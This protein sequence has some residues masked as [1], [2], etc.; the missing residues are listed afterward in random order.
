MSNINLIQLQYVLFFD[1]IENRPDKLINRIDDALDGLFDKMPTILP[2]ADDVPSDLPS[3][4]MQSSNGQFTC[5]ISRT[6]IDIIMNT[7]PSG[8][9]LSVNL[10]NFI[11]KVKIFT[12]T[13]NRFRN[14]NRFG[15]IGRYFYK[16]SSPEKKIQSKY[17]KN[18]MGELNELNLRF[19]K[20]FTIE[21]KEFNDVV[22]ISKGFVTENGRDISSIVIQRD[23]NNVPDSHTIS[24]AEVIAVI[25]ANQN[26]FSLSGISELME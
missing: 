18:D 10:Q 23:M 25:E 9:S 3:V 7:H 4:I 21:D 11:D 17:F 26:K 13:V 19:N 22:E 6:R 1:G 12:E 2:I 15:F 14:F 16:H 24:E 8:N 5:N 20:R